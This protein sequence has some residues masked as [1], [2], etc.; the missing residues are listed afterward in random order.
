[1]STFIAVDQM[2]PLLA[3]IGMPGIPELAIVA[4]IMLLLFGHRLPS[5][6]RSLG[7]GITEF[8]KGVQG[9]EDEL[10]EA[11]TSINNDSKK[12]ES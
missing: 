12:D 1:M 10:E 8:K 2:Q 11:T 4:L 3:L 7:K 9:V 5:M 6:M